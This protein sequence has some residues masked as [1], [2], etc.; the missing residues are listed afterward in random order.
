VGRRGALLAGA[1]LFL[2]GVP[3]RAD[4]SPPPAP[5]EWVTDKSGLLSAGTTSYLNARLRHYEESTGHQVLVYL[6][7]DTGG[8]TPEGYGSEAFKAWRVGRKGVDDGAVL[9]LF[10]ED[11][12]IHIEVGYGL[13]DRLPDAIASRIIR[14]QIVP[15]LQQSR[16]D[17]AVTAG[18]TGILQV[19][20]GEA[21]APGVA[22]VAGPQAPR[23]PASPLQKAVIGILIVLFLLLLVTHPRLA[24]ELLLSAQYASGGGGGS[25]YGGGGY[26]GGGGRSGGG[27][28]SGSW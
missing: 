17:D 13:E 18:V 8:E 7:P 28:A 23:R 1:W 26:S 16:P 15:A 11:R 9:F 19:L 12:K 27:G 3:A 2:L 25:G 24:L 10:T 14:E 21:G 4:W 20:G 6:T 5:T 22:P